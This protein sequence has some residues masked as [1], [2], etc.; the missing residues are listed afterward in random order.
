MNKNVE[1][2]TNKPVADDFLK[3]SALFSTEQQSVL[4]T[5]SQINSYKSFQIKLGI[6]ILLFYSGVFI[7]LTHQY[8][9]SRIKHFIYR[10]FVNYI[11][12]MP[13]ITKLKRYQTKLID[14]YFNFNITNIQSIFR[15]FNQ[16]ISTINNFFISTAPN[17]N[18]LGRFIFNNFKSFILLFTHIRRS[19]TA[20]TVTF[21]FSLKNIMLVPLRMRNAFRLCIYE[22]SNFWRSVEQI[23]QIIKLPIEIL[24]VL[25]KFIKSVGDFLHRIE[26]PKKPRLL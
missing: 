5:T 12:K 10:Y 22:I 25:F 6:Y 19:F 4:D 1:I 24:A 3:S 20:I 13:I 14:L 17:A 7:I 16:T 23:I 8:E 11:L 21:A 2:S 15:S 26:K 9:I 18:Y